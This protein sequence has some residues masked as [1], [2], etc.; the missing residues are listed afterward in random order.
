[1]RRLHLSVCVHANN[2]KGTEERTATPAKSKITANAYRATW[3]TFRLEMC[4]FRV[5]CEKKTTQL[6]NYGPMNRLA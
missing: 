5:K 4:S 6:I 1:M 2:S 3:S